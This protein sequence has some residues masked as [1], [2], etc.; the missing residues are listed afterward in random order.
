MKRTY[1]SPEFTYNKV[2]G[3]YNMVEESGFTSKLLK[4]D[5]VIS[6]LSDNIE[7][8]ELPTGEQLNINSE[9]YLPPITFDAVNDKLNSSTLI[10]D[11]SQSSLDLSTNPKYI[12]SINMS[13][14]T[15]YLFA[16]LKK[17]RTFE[18][19]KNISTIYNSVDTAINNYISNNILPLYVFD[20]IDLFIQPN[21][22]GS[23]NV[24]QYNNVFDSNIADNSTLTK[25]Y[26]LVV[27]NNGSISVNFSPGYNN[28]NSFNYYYNIYFYRI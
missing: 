20:H 23:N 10:L 7:Y 16:T 18:G 24:Y 25:S 15:N 21:G 9:K 13:V 22:L 14:L 3:T 11:P 26:K 4:T 12:L 27:N 6:I 17:W 8:Y 1:I 19:V 5:S 28:L 2:Y